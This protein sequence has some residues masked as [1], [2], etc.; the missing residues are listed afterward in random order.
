VDEEGGGTT[1]ESPDATSRPS[2]DASTFYKAYEGHAT[3]L[4]AWL[5]AYGVG[6]PVLVLTNE[7]LSKVIADAGHSRLLA[8]LFLTGVTLQV[9]LAA[10]NKY[11]MW[12]LY[13]SEGDQSLED[14]WP[15]SWAAW[16]SWQV[17]IDFSVDAAC[18]GAFGYATYRIL[19]DVAGAT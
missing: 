4:R 12:L 6:G 5:V 13:S 1:A 11:S 7:R 9:L 14:K 16:I 15:Y 10:I 17:W 19:I 2:G 3:T 18:L 8:A